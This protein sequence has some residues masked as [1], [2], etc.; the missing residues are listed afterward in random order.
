MR[1]Y[2]KNTNIF[3]MPGNSHLV[4]MATIGY[5]LREFVA[6]IGVAGSAKGNA[7][8][9]EVVLTSIDYDKDVYANLKF[10]DDD[11]LAND[12]AEWVQEKGLLDMK[13]RGFE[14]FEQG[15]KLW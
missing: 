12:L 9:E 7:Y 14:S 6:M 11:N 15:I 3:S 13:E 8:I 4:H 5:G 1:F 10:I 2:L